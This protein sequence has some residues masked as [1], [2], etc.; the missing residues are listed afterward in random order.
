[1]QTDLKLSLPHSSLDDLLLNLISLIAAEVLILASREELERLT[2]EELLAEE[3]L[4]ALFFTCEEKAKEIE[5]MER[6]IETMNQSLVLFEE[7]EKYLLR[8]RVE[9]WPTLQEA[10]KVITSTSDMIYQSNLLNDIYD[11]DSC[12]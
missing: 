11:P 7:R 9:L 8:E 10:G 3:E 6:E 2:T 12:Q 5:T 1:M 4:K